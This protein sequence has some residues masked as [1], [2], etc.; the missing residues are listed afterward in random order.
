MTITSSQVCGMHGEVCCESNSMDNPGEDNFQSKK[1]IKN[2]IDNFIN[3]T[4]VISEVPQKGELQNHK[5]E[6]NVPECLGN[7]EVPGELQSSPTFSRFYIF[8]RKKSL[9]FFKKFKIFK[10]LGKN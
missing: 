5:K 7:F 8:F 1:T 10:K 6:A 4:V 3:I 2:I 9:F